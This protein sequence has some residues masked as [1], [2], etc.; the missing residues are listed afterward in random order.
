MASSL[1]R[2]VEGGG[3][4]GRPICVP[5]RTSKPTHKQG[6]R[7]IG[8][9]TF[10]SAADP[11][12]GVDSPENLKLKLKPKVLVVSSHCLPSSVRASPLLLV[13][14]LL[15]PIA[16]SSGIARASASSVFIGAGCNRV[17]NNVSWGAC[18][19]VSF[20]AQNAVAIFCPKVTLLS[21]R[22]S[23]HPLLAEL[24]SL[25]TLVS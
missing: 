23:L 8:L 4:T 10:T 12:G 25:F 15:W 13:L 9:S 3:L 18:D 20:G 22:L 14:L 24:S 11:T 17:V 21:P 6:R 2:C 5:N 7:P 16:M 19:L 1:Q